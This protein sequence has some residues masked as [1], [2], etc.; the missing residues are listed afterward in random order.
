MF[1]IKTQVLNHTTKG[2]NTEPYSRPLHPPKKNKNRKSNSI[3]CLRGL[4]E[5]KLSKLEW[6]LEYTHLGRIFVYVL[7]MPRI[8]GRDRLINN[9]KVH[10]WYNIHLFQYNISE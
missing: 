6:V 10:L 5:H 7:R 9:N 8:W 3:L 1:Q 4:L 2:E